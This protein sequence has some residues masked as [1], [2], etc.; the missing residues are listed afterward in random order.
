MIHE[1]QRQAALC[2]EFVEGRELYVGII[3]NRRLRAFPAREILF[4]K[5]D[6]GGPVIATSKVKLD[7][8]YR[9]RWHITYE[10]A[11]LSPEIETKVARVSK[12]IY[13]ALRMRDYGRI[14]LR[15]TASGE[16]V[17]LE[18]NP[19]PNLAADDE[20][21]EAAQQAGISHTHLVDL[22]VQGAR[23]RYETAYAD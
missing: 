1:N 21:A 19:N 18:A 12:R 10:H 11:E 2:E 7:A 14:D 5:K 15:L 20:L 23:R 6:R 13:R 9:R 16:L 3:G 22:I 4:G 17:F 8:A